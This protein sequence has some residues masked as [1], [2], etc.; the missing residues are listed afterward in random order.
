MGLAIHFSVD[1]LPAGKGRPRF[2]RRGAF[3]RAYTDSKTVAYE[4]AVRAAA[5]AAMGGTQP[6]QTPVALMVWAGMQVP[7]SWSARKRQQA[8]GGLL[9]PS[10]KPDCDNIAKAVMDACNGVLYADDKQVV[11][12]GVR[13]RY[14]AEPGVEIYCFEVLP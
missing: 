6:L 8:L 11:N 7:A 4:A 3:T 1:V 2:A 14:A 9:L 13:K 12:L 10:V 5:A